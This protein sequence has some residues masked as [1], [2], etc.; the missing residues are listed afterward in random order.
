MIQGGRKILRN[1]LFMPT[2]TARTYN[3]TI[4]N[5]YEHLKKQGKPTKVALIA[6]MRKLISI[7]NYL[8]KT[9]QAWN[10]AN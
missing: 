1:G 9:N 2:M 5:F 10:P 8:V 7:L 6:C 4:K 3:P